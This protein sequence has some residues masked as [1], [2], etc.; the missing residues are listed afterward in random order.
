MPKLKR[1]IKQNKPKEHRSKKIKVRAEI[2]DLEKI[3]EAS[4]TTKT[5]KK[6][7]INNIINYKKEHYYKPNGG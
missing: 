5:R 1:E 7:Q 4:R 6:V 2:Y 3:Y